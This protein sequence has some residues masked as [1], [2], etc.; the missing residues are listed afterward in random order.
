MDVRREKS[1]EKLRHALA[2]LLRDQS[3]EQISIEQI[4]DKAGVTRPTF[5]SNYQSRQDIIIEHVEHWL[6]RRE[7]LFQ[8]FLEDQ[9]T[10]EPD[11]L[12]AFI[13]HLLNTLSPDDTLLQ[14]ALS[15]R[16]GEQALQRV[17]NQNTDF[18]RR[19]AS[20]SFNEPPTEDDIL[21]IS[22]FYGSATIGIISGV[23]SGKIT[24]QPADLARQLA[25]MIYNGIGHRLY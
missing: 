2:E 4:T 15:G 6:A 16:A 9:Q 18:F 20:R 12:V 24:Q 25:A 14:L 1:R 13:E 10:P 22:T 5:Y 17:T 21:L 11:R 19:R 23:I 3:L 7:T 8:A